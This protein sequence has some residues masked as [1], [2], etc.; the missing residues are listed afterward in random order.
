M[1]RS[2]AWAIPLSP[3]GAPRVHRGGYL[4][5]GGLPPALGGLEWL[6]L[7]AAL[8][9]DGGAEHLARSPYLRRLTRLD[10]QANVI[11][12]A[13]ARTMGQSRNFE[14]LQWLNLT[15]NA[16][17]DAG[18]HDLFHS[19]NMPRLE[20]LLLD[21]T[22]I[23]PRTMAALAGSTTAEQALASAKFLINCRRG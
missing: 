8:L 23:G 17:T 2:I 21:H 15:R 9:K 3:T 13:G 6:G 22:E 20:T 10:L 19:A 16:L 4:A 5:V 12:A 7:Q 1:S 14:H 11:G 18:G